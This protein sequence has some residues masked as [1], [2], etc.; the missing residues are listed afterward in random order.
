MCITRK[1]LDPLRPLAK[2]SVYWH[3]AAPKDKNYL[4]DCEDYIRDSLIPTL[5]ISPILIESAHPPFHTR[6][7]PE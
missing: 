6:Q 1:R 2:R 4:D 3:H 5:Y 7:T